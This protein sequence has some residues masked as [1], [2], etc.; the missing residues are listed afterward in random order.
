MMFK[1]RYLLLGSDKNCIFESYSENTLG[2][3]TAA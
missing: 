1:Q 3:T 2:N